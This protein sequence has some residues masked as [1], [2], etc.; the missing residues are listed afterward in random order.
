M[1]LIRRFHFYFHLKVVMEQFE[2]FV[3]YQELMAAQMHYYNFSYQ[4]PEI[5]TVEVEGR[6]QLTREM[7]SKNI[8]KIAQ[9]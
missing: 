6:Y 9:A 4:K 7:P 1:F 8:S 5:G 2:S 3:I